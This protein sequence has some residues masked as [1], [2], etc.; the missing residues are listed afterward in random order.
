MPATVVQIG[1]ASH[2][3]TFCQLQSQNTHSYF[4]GQGLTHELFTS[5]YKLG[6][7]DWLQSYRRAQENRCNH[8]HNW[9]TQTASSALQTI[10]LC[11]DAEKHRPAALQHLHHSVVSCSVGDSSVALTGSVLHQEAVFSVAGKQPEI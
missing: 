9:A 6:S 2:I 1:L 7:L 10:G 4:A 11:F 5:H 8:C 3:N